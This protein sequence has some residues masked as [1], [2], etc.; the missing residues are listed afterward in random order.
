MLDA[1]AVTRRDAFDAGLRD[2]GGRKLAEIGWFA[3]CAWLARNGN[4][5]MW[6]V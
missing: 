3:P 1:V 2:G 6:E 4:V 5:G